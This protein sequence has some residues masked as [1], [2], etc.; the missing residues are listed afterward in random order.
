MLAFL[1]KRVRLVWIFS[2]VSLILCASGCAK[3]APQPAVRYVF[4]I[5]QKIE[6]PQKP[7]FYKI[8]STKA[9]NSKTNFKAL[10]RNVV[11]LREYNDSLIDVLE[12]Y[13]KKIDDMTAEQDRL[14]NKYSEQMEK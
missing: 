8:D 3:Q 1:G 10:Q 12:H 4:M 6:R 11:L 7:T 13:E 14:V 2:I 5:P 9:A